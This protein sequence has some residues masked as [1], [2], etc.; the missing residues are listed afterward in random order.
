MCR[1]KK[2]PLTPE[3]MPLVDY[4]GHDLEQR[5]GM[6]LGL[7]NLPRA[8][9]AEVGEIRTQGG[10]GL[11]HHEAGDVPGAIGHQFAPPEPDEERVILVVEVFRRGGERRFAQRAPCLSEERVRL[12]FARVDC[13]HL[14][15]QLSF[16]R[17]RQKGGEERI[18]AG[19]NPLLAGYVVRLRHRV[20]RACAFHRSTPLIGAR[21]RTAPQADPGPESMSSSPPPSLNMSLTLQSSHI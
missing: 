16:R 1:E 10:Q 20:H 2:V 11:V 4:H 9:E 15:D 17:L 18:S 14:L 6:V 12:G 3:A 13:C 19:A 21:K 7:E 5:A 8:L